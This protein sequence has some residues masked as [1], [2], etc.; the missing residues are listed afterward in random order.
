M[1]KLFVWGLL[2]SAVNQL[3]SQE[4][5]L[6]LKYNPAY[7]LQ[8]N[9]TPLTKGAEQDFS[10]ICSSQRK[11]IINIVDSLPDCI[12]KDGCLTISVENIPGNFIYSIYSPVNNIDEQSSI[13]GDTSF[14]FCELPA[15]PYFISIL[16]G[17]GNIHQAQYELNNIGVDPLNSANFL[18]IKAFCDKPGKFAR[19]FTD[20]ASLQ[21]KIVGID[22]D[23]NIDLEGS[24]TDLDIGKYYLRV[25]R[26]G[27]KCAAYLIFD[28]EEELTAELP[29]IDDFSTTLVYP[30]VNY[31]EDNYAFVNQTL[32]INAPSLGVV[33]LDGF[34]EVG[35][36]Y[37]RIETGTGLKEG[38]ADVLTSRPFCNAPLSIDNNDT[39]FFSFFYQAEGLGDYPNDEDSL[40]L[41]FL[42]SN[43]E[44]QI[45][46]A[47]A[48]PDSSHQNNPQFTPVQLSISDS[49]YFW[50]GFKFRF[51]NV[52][53][54]SGFND[55]WHLD[56][57]SVDTDKGV[58]PQVQDVTFSAPAPNM[59]KHY[60][61]M[62]W[63]HF[64][65]Y[66]DQELATKEEAPISVRNNEDG[67]VSRELTH[68]IVEACDDDPLYIFDAGIADVLGGI[69]GEVTTRNVFLQDTI[70]TRLQ[71]LDSTTT[72]FDK[73]SV[74]LANK[75]TLT[76]DNG[77]VESNNEM[78]R[79][80]KF[81]NYFAYDDGT[82]E[83][84]YALFGTGAKLAYQFHLNEAD[85]LQA[86][87]FMFLD[88]NANA[89]N[90][91]F[92]IVIWKNVQ[93]GTNKDS[94]IYRSSSSETPNYLN[95]KNGFWTYELD[96]TLIVED[97]IF[98]G[99]EQ[100]NTDY[101][102]I[103]FDRN[104]DASSNVLINLNGSWE[105]SIIPGSVMIRPVVS[106]GALPENVNVGLPTAFDNK[107]V[108][109]YPNPATDRLFV[110][111][112]GSKRAAYLQV[113]DYAG[114]LL[115]TATYTGSLD[116]AYLAKGF[117]LLKI[118]DKDFN[119][120]KTT[121]FVKQ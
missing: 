105:P 42:A 30:D 98:V 50:N 27:S 110:E 62:P 46:W 109:V 64:I 39:L 18:F 83:K 60:Q 59:L 31:W 107:K 104:T 61:S 14:T 84:S 41:E 78:Y 13:T 95:Q 25:K 103:G 44:W 86:L 28:I 94:V 73:D 89:S 106:R 121:K 4:T 101:L 67:V 102:N 99:F 53:T 24:V 9:P 8:K 36:P 15:A 45:I 117:Y 38:N 29:F 81:F 93:A 16:D 97:T 10:R 49:L 80:Q 7:Q 92:N 120:I 77:L 68:S 66:T 87:Q 37:D 3:W 47:T 69:G 111:V 6:P 12:I 88:M 63:N 76:T 82:A 58:F 71:Q 114:Q 22:N 57:I 96:S 40:V 34:N 21:Y 33:T 5:L 116:I 51:R 48:G 112:T 79:Y 23:T 119:K 113:Y 55:H 35:Q 85:T 90:L 91:E 56:Y 20:D 100:R 26:D 52:A 108:Q 54:I 43:Q 17:E 70:A 115:S 32:A 65:N 2:I 72:A 118:F 1:K 74:V 11:P 19:G 75:W